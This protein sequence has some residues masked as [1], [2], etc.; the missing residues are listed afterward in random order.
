M[1]TFA[2]LATAVLALATFANAAP[3][4]INYQGV[5]TDQNGNP[6]NGV[7]AMQIKIYDAP[8]G[9][10]LLY[11]EDLGNVPVQDGIYSFS[12]GANGT[13]N[14]LTTETVAI[15]NGIVSTFQKVLAAP[16]VV[17]GSVTVT[18]GTYTWDQTNGS[19]N[20]NDF[21]VAYSPNLRR[22]AVTYYNGAPAAGKTISVKF[23]APG[24]GIAGA[25]GEIGSAWTELSVGGAPQ[26]NRQKILAVPFALTALKLSNNN[27]PG[28]LSDISLFTKVLAQNAGISISE[29]LKRINSSRDQLGV[30]AE[31]DPNF[32]FQQTP[33]SIGLP[34]GGSM[35]TEVRINS[36]QTYTTDNDGKVVFTYID[37][38][39]KN[40]AFNNASQ[41]NPGPLEFQCIN[42]DPL[43]K[44]SSIYTEFF[45]WTQGYYVPWGH[46]VK[47]ITNE[48]SSIEFNC[49]NT[50][51]SQVYVS[52][53]A[54]VNEIIN[55]VVK[56]KLTTQDIYTCK[57]N[58]W[59]DLPKNSRVATIEVGGY[60]KSPQIL[61][62]TRIKVLFFK[63]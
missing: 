29:I 58:E 22:V 21:S 9:G 33:W 38:S 30:I 51:A 44:V 17:A 49:N 60:L 37:G 40:V 61:N 13:S 39:K 55:D 12:F 47:V 54:D 19:S 16:T 45:G 31:T 41:K 50:A 20:E 4:E 32:S 24:F 34:I 43:K 18:D 3:T 10:T 46:S 26:N 23:R 42:P 35:V 8:T 53:E 56:V 15:A 25:L 11:S 48:Y 57:W 62:I 14:A 2:L 52:P 27:E 28:S 5:L 63:D 1:K 6:V 7:R 59:V 36:R